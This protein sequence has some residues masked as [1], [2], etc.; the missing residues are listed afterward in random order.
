MA[1]QTS[2]QKHHRTWKP[3]NAS[4]SCARQCPMARLSFTGSCSGNSWACTSTNYEQCLCCRGHK[5]YVW[6]LSGYVQHFPPCRSCFVSLYWSWKCCSSTC[7]AHER[8]RWVN[9]H[10]L[11]G[12]EH[13]YYLFW[14]CG[15]EKGCWNANRC[16]KADLPYFS[17]SRVCHLSAHLGVCRSKNTR[18]SSGYSCCGATCLTSTSL[19]NRSQ[20]ICWRQKWW[21]FQIDSAFWRRTL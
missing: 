21:R 9:F 8:W 5:R 10:V 19:W 14:W 11:F 2:H 20:V 6:H 16:S 17:C 7:C 18:K 12:C 1:H 13:L 3:A 15:G 4:H